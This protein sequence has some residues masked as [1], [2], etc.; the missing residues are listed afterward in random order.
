MTIYLILEISNCTKPP[1]TIENVIR[2]LDKLESNLKHMLK[3][4]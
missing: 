1:S 2:L 4:L 3:K